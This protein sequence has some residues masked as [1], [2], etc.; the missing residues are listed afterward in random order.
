MNCCCLA[1]PSSNKEQRSILQEAME[2]LAG[3]KICALEM[4]TSY[5]GKFFKD[6][7]SRRDEV[8]LFFFLDNSYLS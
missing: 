2:N 5:C 4:S 1:S 3:K 6:G 7:R 8:T